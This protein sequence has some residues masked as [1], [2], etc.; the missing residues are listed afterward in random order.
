MRTKRKI[1]QAHYPIQP[2]LG[3]ENDHFFD[4]TSIFNKLNSRY[5]KNSLLG[6][7]IT[8]GRKMK[9]RPL[10]YFVFGT[11]QEEDRII[12]IHPLLDQSWVPRW[13]LEFVVFH[14]MLHAVVPD[15][16]DS[17]GR[18]IIHHAG[19]LERERRF[20]HFKRAQRWEK[21]NLERFLR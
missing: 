5:F 9:K 7:T 20:P 19:F 17:A 13:F 21:Q 14:E 8:W 18:R 2:E 15:R 4:L 12:R 10:R 11:I 16:Y 1:A 6:Y 3:L